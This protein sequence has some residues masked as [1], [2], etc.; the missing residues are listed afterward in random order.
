MALCFTEK[1]PVDYLCVKDDRPILGVPNFQRLIDQ[2]F[3]ARQR[4]ENDL[5]K[6]KLPVSVQISTS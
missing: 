5:K 1:L 4:I 6:P 2:V 3:S